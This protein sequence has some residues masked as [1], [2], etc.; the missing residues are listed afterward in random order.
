MPWFENLSF[1]SGMM[2]LPVVRGVPW[3]RSARAPEWRE[4]EE[5]G[6]FDRYRDEPEEEEEAGEPSAR[7]AG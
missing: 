6:R 2:K 5:E 7:T 3:M 1:P 4:E